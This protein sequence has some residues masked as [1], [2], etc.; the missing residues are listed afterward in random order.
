MSRDRQI[1]CN[2]ICNPIKSCTFLSNLRNFWD[3]NEQSFVFHFDLLFFLVYNNAHI[4]ISFLALHLRLWEIL[5]NMCTHNWTINFYF[6]WN[7]FSSAGA[8]NVRPKVLA[9]RLS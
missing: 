5:T 4:Q 7:K 8:S 1:V 6:W 9:R 2:Q 3:P